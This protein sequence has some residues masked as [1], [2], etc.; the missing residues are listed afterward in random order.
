[1]NIEAGEWV[2][3]CDGRKALILENKGDAKFPNLRSKETHEHKETRT[4]EIGTDRPG[5]VQQSVGT[6]H[7]SVV[8]TDFHDQ[9]ERAFLATIARRLHEAVTQSQASGLIIVAPPRALGALREMYSPA[10]AKAVRQELHKDL[11]RA[12]IHEIEQHLVA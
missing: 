11:V 6:A 10:V 12:P 4:S 5:R 9:S 7:A 2:V 1:M 8:Q 3:V